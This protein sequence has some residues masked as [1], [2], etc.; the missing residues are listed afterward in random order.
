LL[1]RRGGFGTSFELEKLKL[2]EGEEAGKS[3]IKK[4]LDEGYSISSGIL[5]HL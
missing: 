4:L 2:E 1:G 3:F 5:R